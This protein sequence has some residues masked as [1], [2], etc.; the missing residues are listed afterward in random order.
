MPKIKIKGL[1]RF[2]KELDDYAS[3]RKIPL[4]CPYCEGSFVAKPGNNVC[5]HCG[6]A[7]EVQK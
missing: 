5:P 7:F 2:Q 3:L 4:T 6:K 1:D